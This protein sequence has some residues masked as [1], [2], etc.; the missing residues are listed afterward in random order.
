[1]LP[2]VKAACKPFREFCRFWITVLTCWMRSLIWSTLISAA[3][4]VGTVS[5]GNDGSAMEPS[6]DSSARVLFAGGGGGTK[7]DS[8]A[9]VGDAANISAGSSLRH[10]GHTFLP[11]VKIQ[12]QKG[13]RFK[14][15]PDS[16]LGSSSASDSGATSGL[17]Q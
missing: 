14:T 9:G 8:G 16:A 12:L 15:T 13:Q 11:G 17:M 7:L 6:A 10:M 2:A 3:G 4:V 1:M 5:S